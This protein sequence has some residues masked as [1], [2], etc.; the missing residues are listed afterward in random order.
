MLPN[1]LGRRAAGALV[2]MAVALRGDDSEIPW[3]E[4][5][6]R[7][8]GLSLLADG[9]EATRQP[10]HHCAAYLVQLPIVPSGPGT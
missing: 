3:G 5:D 1:E 4:P 8:P 7:T 10:G 6:R 9:V 2:S